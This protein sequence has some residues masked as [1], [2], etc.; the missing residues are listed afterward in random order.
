MY[1]I[2]VKQHF[3]SAHKL[4]D[5]NGDCSK[6]HGHNWL[7]KVYAIAKELNNIG[8]SLDFKNFKKMVRLEISE[9][10]HKYLNDLPE[11]KEKNPTAEIIAEVLY[12][13]L[14][15]LDIEGIEITAVEVWESENQGAK[16]FE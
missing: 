4:Q 1:E 7:V 3:S 11:F 13:K 5:Y 2:F 12:Q 10:D 14:K 6:L 15:K 16:Y 9:F 8:I